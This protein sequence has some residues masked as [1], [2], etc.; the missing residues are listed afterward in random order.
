MALQE[1]HVSEPVASTAKDVQTGGSAVSH[2]RE[3]EHQDAEHGEDHAHGLDW[4]EFARIAVVAAAAAAVW[5][6]LWE[7]FAYVSLIGVIGL[8]VGGWPIFS[9]A[10]ENLTARRMTME[11]SM[12]I[13]I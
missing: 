13:A 8:A 3:A 1:D 12:S 2:E 10:A 9:E 11:L 4:V 5:F 6:Q 7:P